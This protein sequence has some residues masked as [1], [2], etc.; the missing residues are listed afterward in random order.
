MSSQILHRFT[1]F[2]TV[3][4]RLPSDS[5]RHDLKNQ[6]GIIL[7]FSDLL[8]GEMDSA[9]PRRPDIQ[10]IS[11]AVH[12]ALELLSEVRLPGESEENAP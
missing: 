6:L 12:R 8:L 1:D 9:D 2:G 3:T 4:L 11:T 5:W 7:G 10:E